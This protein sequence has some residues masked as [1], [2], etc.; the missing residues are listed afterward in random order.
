MKTV[1]MDAVV[2]YTL[3]GGVVLS[4][5]LIAVGLGWHWTLYGDW[6]FTYS[7][8]PTTVGGFILADVEQLASLATRPRLLVNLGIAILMLTPYVR[9]VASV[10]AFAL[11]RNWKYLAFT[12]FVLL[13]LTY[14]LFA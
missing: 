7:L 1:D 3:L 8:P 11:Q 5:S 13:T 4:V 12:T 10:V 9:V 2:G 14:S 6:R